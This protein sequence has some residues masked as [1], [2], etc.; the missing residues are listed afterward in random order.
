MLTFVFFVPFGGVFFSEKLFWNWDFY[1]VPDV[2]YHCTWCD[3]TNSLSPP[4]LGE[5]E[6]WRWKTAHSCWLEIFVMYA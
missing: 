5:Q 2:W 4:H 1:L 6:I 3:C